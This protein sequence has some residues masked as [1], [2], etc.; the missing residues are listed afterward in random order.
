MAS[1]EWASRHDEAHSRISSRWPS[2]LKNRYGQ[3]KLLLHRQN[4]W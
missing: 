4:V 2:D 1:V 3:N